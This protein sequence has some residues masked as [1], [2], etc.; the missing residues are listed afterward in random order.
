[1]TQNICAELSMR[2]INSGWQRAEIQMVGDLYQVS[3]TDPH[4]RE[5]G[6]ARKNV[7]SLVAYLIDIGAIKA[8][9]PEKPISGELAALLIGGESLEDGKIR[10]LREY[11]AL[12]QKLLDD[13]YEMGRTE[14]DRHESISAIL[15]EL[16]K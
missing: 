2:M 10:L 14:T 16:R 3:A 12:T 6:G 13:K 8:A 5:H 4:G 9:E 7:A 1:M 15:L 11:D